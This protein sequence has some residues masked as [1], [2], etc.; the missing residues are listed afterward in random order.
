MPPASQS[1]TSAILR[2]MDAPSS[3]S[4][5]D[6][7]VSIPAGSS[8]PPKARR[9]GAAV[10]SSAARSTPSAASRCAPARPPSA[11]APAGRDTTC[12]DTHDSS[13]RR[14][15]ARR[16][17][18]ARAAASACRRSECPPE[19]AAF[20][21]SRRRAAGSYPCL[22]PLCIVCPFR[23]GENLH[24]RRSLAGGQALAQPLPCSPIVSIASRMI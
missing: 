8:R 7:I 24:G 3:A 19:R 21:R 18:D 17:P 13:R 2:G 12:S 15:A 6:F 16:T 5:L 10:T 9:S 14:R 22:S 20:G 23:S 4:I 11:P 1:R